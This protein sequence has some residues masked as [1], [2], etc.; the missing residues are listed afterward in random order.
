LEQGD[1]EQ[2]GC[3]DTIFRD[4]RPLRTPI[5]VV[6]VTD[7]E[8]TTTSMKRRPDLE[9]RDLQPELEDDAAYMKNCDKFIAE[10]DR[11]QEKL[12][13]TCGTIRASLDPA[14]RTKFEDIRYKRAPKLLWQDIND[15]F[16][17]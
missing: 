10:Y 1:E 14:I 13:K 9:T 4:G 2:L 8:G 16:E 11:Y 5:A 3:W 12:S 15:E 6:T 7:T 17:K